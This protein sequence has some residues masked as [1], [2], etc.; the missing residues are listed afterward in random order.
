MKLLRRYF[1]DYT[2]GKLIFPDDSYCYTLERPDLNNKAFV[3]CVPEGSYLVDRDKTGK[4]R[5]YKIRE[6]QIKG[7]SFIEIHPA[8]KVDQLQGCIAPC[9]SV[10][11]GV[12]KDSR[13]ACQ[14]LME[15]FDDNSFH[16]TI[17]KYNPFMD[18]K[19]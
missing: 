2:I 9:M 3:S 19:W 13:I 15:W 8:T 16:L 14:K 17:T 1:K 11:K 12:G 18:G 10:D 7:R 5:W 6:G 4:H